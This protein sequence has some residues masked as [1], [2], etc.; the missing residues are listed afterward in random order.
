MKD[1]IY[2]DL[3]N[4]DY[5]SG[6]GVSSSGIRIFKTLPLAYWGA[7]LSPDR[8][9]REET[10]SQKFGT[11]FHA[12]MLEPDLYEKTYV[13]PPEGVDRRSKDGKAFF[14]ELESKGNI[15]ISAEQQKQIAMMVEAMRARPMVR[16][17]MS[18]AYLFE[19]SIFVTDP[20][21]GIQLKI[22]PDI[23]I[24]PCTAFPNGLIGDVK[25]T[26]DA[27]PEGFAK[28]ASNY[29]YHIQAAFYVDVF[30]MAFQ[31]KKPPAFIF[32]AIE[33]DYPFAANEFS[34]S[35]GHIDLGRSEYRPLLPQ[36]AKCFESGVWPGYSTNLE[37]LPMTSWDERR[38]IEL[39][40]NE[41]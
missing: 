4:H 35:I 31:T 39:S 17:I 29:E 7:Y 11:A 27:S 38:L 26:T 40:N 9:P 20:E 5:H 8:P 23:M 22:R 36:M 34:T 3:S 10:A 41:D 32:L 30:Q 14:A 1:G 33:K 15:V 19:S 25:T 2:H 28:S 13:V 18:Q 21:T 24:E 6:A 16:A 12:A 37:P